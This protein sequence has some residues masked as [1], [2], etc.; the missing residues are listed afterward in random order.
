M[1]DGLLLG[2]GLGDE[3]YD[4]LHLGRVEEMYDGLLL[5]IGEEMMFDGVGEEMYN[6]PRRGDVRWPPPWRR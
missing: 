4:G 1:Y 5:G 2:L 6:G 3:V